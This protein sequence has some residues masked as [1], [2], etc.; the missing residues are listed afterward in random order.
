MIEDVPRIFEAVFQCTLEVIVKD[1][2]LEIHYSLW[3]ECFSF[4]IK[5][6][7]PVLEM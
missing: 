7:G 3:F 2:R 1:I 4:E 5:Y 6:H